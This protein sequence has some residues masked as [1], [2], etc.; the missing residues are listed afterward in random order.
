MGFLRCGKRVSYKTGLCRYDSFGPKRVGFGCFPTRFAQVAAAF[1]GSWACGRCAC[2]RGA[3]EEGRGG[4]GVGAMGSCQGVFGRTECGI[5]AGGGGAPR[6]L[7]WS[8]RRTG[9]GAACGTEALRQAQGERRSAPAMWVGGG[10]PPPGA[11][12]DTGFRRYD[13]GGC[14]KYG[15]PETPL[16]RAPALGSRCD[17][18]GGSGAACRYCVGSPHPAPLDSCLRRN[19]ARRRRPRAAPLPWVPAFARTTVGGV[20][21]TRGGWWWR[22]ALRQAQGERNLDSAPAMWVGGGVPP[23]GAPLDTGFRRYD[24]GGCGN[25]RE[26]ETAPRRAPALGSRF[27]G[28]DGGPGSGCRLQVGLPHP[29]PLD[30]CLA[31]MTLGGGGRPRAAPLPWVPASSRNDGGGVRDARGCGPRAPSTGSG[32]TESRSQSPAMWVG[33][34]AP[35]GAPRIPAFAGTTIGGCGNYETETAPR[36]RPSRARAGTSCLSGFPPSRERRYS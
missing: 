19:D 27:R 28:N 25:V 9:G 3:W 20:C 24:D 33:G 35:P 13:D 8:A 26:T 17:D 12:L 23:P 4:D 21:G 7:P 30:S 6:N 32:R 5:G 14:G 2:V 10:V 31:G 18:G 34:G 29:A 15:E 1:A 16:R 11:P 36:P 22:R